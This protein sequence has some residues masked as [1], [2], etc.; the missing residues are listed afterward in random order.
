MSVIAVTNRN[1]EDEVL[2]S[3][4]PVLIDFWA[5]WCAPCRMM[6]PVI[7]EI[8]GERPDVKVG[9]VNVDDEPE[10]AAK[11]GITSI[12]TV[13]VM[14]NGVLAGESVGVKPKQSIIDML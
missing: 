13:V 11:F 2:N 10:L 14:K 1:Y 8:A 5:H 6:A 7:D 9:K 12:P 4:K 3:D